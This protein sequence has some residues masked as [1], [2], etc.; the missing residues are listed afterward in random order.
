MEDKVQDHRN[1]HQIS[2][3]AV[4]VFIKSDSFAGN[5][6]EIKDIAAEHTDQTG[7]KQHNV[8]PVVFL[9][10]CHGETS[11]K[12]SGLCLYP[13]YKGAVFEFP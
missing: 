12:Y 4:Q 2:T 7:K 3:D 8:N 5:Q 9:Y 11:S 1:C 6:S 10:F 13:E